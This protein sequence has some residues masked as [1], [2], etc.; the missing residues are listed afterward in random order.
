MP[1]SQ[2]TGFGATVKRVEVRGVPLVVWM[3]GLLDM[4]VMEV[5]EGRPE[6]ANAGEDE[7]RKCK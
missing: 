2:D 7:R 6:G 1:S 4:K 5:E 3:P